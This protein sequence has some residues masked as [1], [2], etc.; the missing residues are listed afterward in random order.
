MPSHL[1]DSLVQVPPPSDATSKLKRQLREIRV[2]II[3]VV[4]ITLFV[5]ICSASFAL[6]QAAPAP[7]Q[8]GTID[9]TNVTCPGVGLRATACFALDIACPNIPNYTAFVKIIEPKNPVGAIIF[10]IGGLVN[11]LYE[12]YTYGTIA[13]E[14]VLN[15]HFTVVELTYGNPFSNG[16]GWQH[17]VNGLGVRVAACRYATVAQWVYN[18]VARGP[19]CATGSSA[20]G[21]LIGQGLAH[22]G[23]GNYLAFA[24]ITSG[25][26]FQRV[27]YACIND[28]KIETEYCSGANVGM[29]V[30]YTNAISFVDP[31][32][33][34]P[35]CSSSL[36]TG[37]KQYQ[38]QFLDDSVTSPDAELSYPNTKVRFL[39]GGLDTSSAIRQGL[40]YQSK[41]L[42]PTTYA[43]V[44]DAPHSIPDVLDGAQKIASDLITNCHH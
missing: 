10:T 32:Y 30:G 43:C 37:S 35:W 39:F 7:D 36:K 17:D 18:N 29:G 21:E 11:D 12:N 40:D 14:G 41:I 28:V 15:S 20:G 8:M 16:P 26:P 2:K 42:Q 3:A 34:G 5:I 6:G 24:E 31:A 1:I 38:Q 19:L 23:L 22:Y 4:S 13:L 27:D 33:P 44:K 25:P 9:A